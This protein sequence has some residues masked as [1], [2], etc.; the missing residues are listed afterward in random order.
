MTKWE[1]ALPEGTNKVLNG[2][3][4]G[5]DNLGLLLDK[6]APYAHYEWK[7]N[8]SDRQEWRLG[9]VTHDDR[10]KEVKLEKGDWLRYAVGQN[11]INKGDQ[12]SRSLP[13][14]K[15]LIRAYRG[16]WEATCTARSSG[17]NFI[18]S[19]TTAAPLII[20][21]GAKHILDTAITL[22]RNTGLPV[23]PGSALK[24]LARTVALVKLATHIVEE[25]TL[26]VLP[27]LDGWIAE[28]TNWEALAEM[29]G[30]TMTE[31]EQ[32]HKSTVELFRKQFGFR[33]QSGSVIFMDGIYAET[34]A[35]KY[36][37]D[38]MN[39]HYRNYYG[40]KHDAPSD[41]QQLNPITYLTVGVGQKFNFAVLPR[42]QADTEY[43]AEVK[44]YLKAGLKEDEGYGIGAKTSQGYGIFTEP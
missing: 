19:M 14:D 23:I 15:N 5:A 37:V 12:G 32:K 18:W 3:I 7:T 8:G 1:W 22:D 44:E 33:D 13:F 21:L 39:V 42:T 11:A 35:P 17:Q 30:G 29:C 38:I 16:R 20:G 9:F 10:G 41:D 31:F 34:T 28:D 4:H 40:A 2:F 36:A 6:F 43:V 26:A 27:K 25:P 24:G